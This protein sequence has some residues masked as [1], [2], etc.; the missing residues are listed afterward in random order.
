MDVTGSDSGSDNGALVAFMTSHTH[1]HECVHVSE[2]ASELAGSKS[3][4][5]TRQA[6]NRSRCTSAVHL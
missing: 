6:Q 2:G 5:L 3:H 4:T 1:L